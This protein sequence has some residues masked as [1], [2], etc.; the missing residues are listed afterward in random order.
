MDDDDLFDNASFT[1]NHHSQSGRFS[2]HPA[3]HSR[4]L[5]HEHESQL[6]IGSY[7]SH[8]EHNPTLN[9][10][11]SV[12]TR[13]TSG[14]VGDPYANQTDF[15]GGQS[16]GMY[17]GGHSPG[18]HY[19]GDKI[20]GS[21]TSHDEQK[22][23]SQLQVLYEARG[24]KIE[25]LQKECEEREESYEKEMRILNHRLILATGKQTYNNIIVG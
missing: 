20:G 24:R 9:D 22:Y 11:A 14:W 19:D 4:N 7:A 12:Y 6:G 3:S 18:N 13:Q 8:E 25:S 17:A 10:N 1:S 15:T 5:R 16:Y 2:D 21:S 23:A